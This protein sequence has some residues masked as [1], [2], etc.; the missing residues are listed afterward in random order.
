MFLLE[1]KIEIFD[2]MVYLENKKKCLEKLELEKEHAQQEIENKKKELE[3]SR[4][5]AIER[6]TELAKNIGEEQVTKIKND[7]RVKM[8]EKEQLLLDDLLGKVAVK[9]KDFTKTDEYVEF[10]KNNFKEVLSELSEGTYKVYLLENDRIKSFFENVEGYEFKFNTLNESYVGGFIIKDEDEN[11][12]IDMSMKSRIDDIRYD[13][14]KLLYSTLKG[15][16]GIC[17]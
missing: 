13:V 3:N 14:G 12:S 17:E 15:V 11:Y 5:E 9:L 4:K 7:T 10:E 6:R 8:L 16:G 2:K 1:K